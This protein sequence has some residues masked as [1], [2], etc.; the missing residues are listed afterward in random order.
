MQSRNP[1]K[2][3]LAPLGASPCD[4]GVALQPLLLG[5]FFRTVARSGVQLQRLV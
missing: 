5:G 4:P 2:K 1:T 3:G